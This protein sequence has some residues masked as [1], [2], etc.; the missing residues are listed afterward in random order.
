M[1]AIIVYE[2]IWGNT[3]DVARAIAGALE[4]TMDVELIDA[5][6]APHNVDGYDL[7]IVG[8]P[9]HAFSMSRPATREAALN[10]NCPSPV[11]SRGIRE[12]IHELRSASSLAPVATFDTRADSPRLPG[13]AARAA[14]HELRLLGFAAEARPISFYVH[15]YDG[16]LLE[17][18]LARAAAWAQGLVTS[19]V[20]AH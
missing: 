12:W 1:R 2:S 9:T 6:D 14:R 7:I 15:G 13:S 19:P 8:G 16:P 20:V 17:G 5:Q 11:R 18:E 4:P 3:Q 10:Q